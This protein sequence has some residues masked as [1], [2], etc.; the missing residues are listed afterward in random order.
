MDVMRQAAGKKLK[1]AVEISLA[2]LAMQ[3]CEFEVN[4]AWGQSQQVGS[5][6]DANNLLFPRFLP[7]VSKALLLKTLVVDCGT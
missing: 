2:Q 7:L 5:D 6:L 3:G 1:S 4:I